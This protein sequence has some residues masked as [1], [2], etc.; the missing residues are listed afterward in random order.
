MIRTLKVL[1][2]D[3]RGFREACYYETCRTDDLLASFAAGPLFGRYWRD[4]RSDLTVD[5][6]IR[7]L[8]SEPGVPTW[9]E[10]TTRRVAQGILSALRDFGIL[11]GAKRGQRKR[12]LPPHLSMRGFAYVALRE[13]RRLRSDRALLGSSVWR[14]YLLDDASLRRLFF[15][16]DRHGILRYS[17][18]GSIV[19]VDWL[20]RDLEGVARVPAA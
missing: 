13:R 5:A 12:I 9:G 1:A 17:E 2:H 6:V 20:I 18:A 19:R 14:W 15:E 10:Y 7:W 11:E 3:P 16:A 4:G 8:R